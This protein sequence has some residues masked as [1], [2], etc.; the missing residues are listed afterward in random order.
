MLHAWSILPLERVI[1]EVAYRITT[2]QRQESGAL[3]VP[4]VTASRCLSSSRLAARVNSTHTYRAWI[5]VA[6]FQTQ[7][8]RTVT[9]NFIQSY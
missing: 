1:D 3:G 6:R 9:S 4:C 2:E 7:S 5:S 8:C